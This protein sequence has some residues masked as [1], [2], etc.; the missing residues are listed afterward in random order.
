MDFPTADSDCLPEYAN[1]AQEKK[2]KPNTDGDSPDLSLS[3]PNHFLPFT[4]F[5]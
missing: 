4:G 1:S 5:I 2:E 3:N